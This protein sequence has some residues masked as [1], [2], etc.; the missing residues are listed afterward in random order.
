M[1]T[2]VFKESEIMTR[3]NVMLERYIKCRDIELKTLRAM[4][5][6]QVLPAAV[7]YKASL[8]EGVKRLKD[9]GIDSALEIDLLKDL[10]ALS[11]SL[12][13]ETSSMAHTL[14]EL[15][16]KGD[17]E[18]MARKIASD[19]MPRSVKIA[20]LCNQIEEIVPDNQWPIPKFFDM[21]FIR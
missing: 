21:L 16:H 15:H 19:L 9:A 12:Y 10:A 8:S 3:H 11:K 14:D 4:V 2:G 17:E 7:A 5:N 1:R 20:Q 13:D 6:Q 18:A